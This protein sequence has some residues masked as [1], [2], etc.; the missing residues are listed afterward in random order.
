M[1]LHTPGLVLKREGA[2][3][4]VERLLPDPMDQVLG[5][6]ERGRVGRRVQEFQVDV[7][8][9]RPG[10]VFADFGQQLG[11]GG[12]HGGP[13]DGGVVEDHGDPAEPPPGIAQHQQDDHHDCVVGFAL[14]AEID[15]RSAPLQ[16]HGEEAVQLLAVAL[17]AWHGRRGVLRRPGVVGVRDGLEGE[18]IQRH[19]RAIRRQSGCFFFKS[20]TKAERLAGLDGP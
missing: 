4:M 18:L 15:I 20:A 10:G 17:V 11:D 2:R 5:R 14:G 19:E 6:V 1:L 9:A 12:L 13:V 7:F 8:Q 3:Q 16:V